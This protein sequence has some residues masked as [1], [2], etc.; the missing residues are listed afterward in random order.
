MLKPLLLLLLLLLPG[1]GH[2]QTLLT[3][4][5]RDSEGAP[6]PAV[7]VRAYAQGAKV[8][9]AYTQTDEKGQYRLTLGNDSKGE[10]RLKF[11]HLSYKPVEVILPHGTQRQDVKLSERAQAFREVTVKSNYVHQR[12]DTLTYR[13]SSLAGKADRN[14]EDVI[15]RIPGIN[16]ATNGE[17]S[18]QG[19]AINRF[20]IEGRDLL[21]GNYGLATRNIKPGDVQSVSV[22]ENHQ[23]VKLLK[24]LE[25]SKQAALNLSLK[26]GALGRLVGNAKM[27]AGAGD[28][29]RW[30][31]E[32]YGM[33]IFPHHQTMYAVK[34]NN[35]A[36]DY[37][38]ET[39]DF[40]LQHSE[41]PIAS[42]FP[43]TPFGTSSLPRR[44]YADNQSAFASWHTL[45]DLGKEKD[46]VLKGQYTLGRHTF[47]QF[48]QSEYYGLQT[49]LVVMEAVDN[50]LITQGVDLSLKY[51]HNSDSA[52]L[53]EKTALRA[54]L[55]RNIYDLPTGSIRQRWR[56]VDV[57]WDNLL[58]WKRRKERH[59]SAWELKTGLS[60]T[61]TAQLTADRES[62][63]AALV[64][65][66]VSALR[67]FATTGTHYAY[68][69][70]ENG[71]WGQVGLHLNIYASY[72]RFTSEQTNLLTAPRNDNWA[73]GAEL[74]GIPH[75]SV[76]GRGFHLEVRLP[77]RY[78][79]HDFHNRYLHTEFLL[80]RPYFVPSVTLLKRWSSLF[81]TGTTAYHVGVGRFQDFLVAPLY[82]TLSAADMAG[83]WC[84]LPVADVAVGVATDVARHLSGAVGEL[85]GH[86]QPHESRPTASIDHWAT[87]WDN[88][89][90]S[91]PRQHAKQL[92]DD[93]AR[94]P[95]QPS[96]PH[97]LCP[98]PPLQWFATLD[99]AATV[100]PH[101]PHPPRLHGLFH[102]LQLVATAVAGAGAGGLGTKFS[103]LRRNAERAQPLEWQ[104]AC[105]L[106]S[107]RALGGGGAGR[108][109][110]QRTA[111]PPLPHL[112]L[113]RR[114]DALQ[115]Q[116]LGSRTATAQ[117]G[118]HA[119]IRSAHLYAHRH[120]HLQLSLTTPRSVALPEMELL[121][122]RKAAFCQLHS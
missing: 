4:T 109:G 5:V 102:R 83:Q 41:T 119:P 11:T 47:S 15:R 75:Y 121:R 122:H 115:A 101:H 85:D 12:G 2:G 43:D 92:D 51:E 112:L 98:F 24:D 9:T 59:L 35:F 21:G 65:Q 108:D 7:I 86:L 50:D 103:P 68:Q 33:Q 1:L 57:S 79:L 89:A 113:P 91:A 56:E 6:L 93:S 111:T 80:N 87:R 8:V 116:A 70:G 72:Q 61:P 73:L 32:L 19:E 31:A 36:E 23:P 105:R 58:V 20:Y 17:I 74:Q 66:E 42:L 62:D 18:Y 39:I 26:R 96:H 76:G 107:G 99:V 77:V 52:Y 49:P 46:L 37:A 13:V 28:G 90:G 3:G 78:L 34:G 29:A 27:G 67:A 54:H 84:A 63:G 55:R 88:L 44:R 40:L 95:L 110:A 48:Q 10:F 82:Q 97:A 30:L 69:L 60:T 118:R 114:P 38:I 14:I 81:V 45:F 16:I 100:A 104:C 120:L 117:P 64:R 25:V 53:A 71:R 94:H 106:H 22:L